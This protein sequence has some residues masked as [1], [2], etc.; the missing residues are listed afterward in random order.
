MAGG[1]AGDRLRAQVAEERAGFHARTRGEVAS[2][3]T[4]MCAWMSDDILRR[5]VERTAGAEA[6][7]ARARMIAQEEQFQ[8]RFPVGGLGVE[9]RAHRTF[10]GAYLAAVGLYVGDELLDARPERGGDGVAL[11]GIYPRG[12]SQLM[13]MLYL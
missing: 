12:V 3:V 10:S 6:P 9:V 13:L 11:P 5:E 8:R 1:S 4:G 7:E 2:R